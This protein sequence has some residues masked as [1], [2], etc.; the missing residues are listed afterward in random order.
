M[1]WGNSLLQSACCPDFAQIGA[2]PCY[3]QSLKGATAVPSSQHAL[4]CFEEQPTAKVPTSTSPFSHPGWQAPEFLCPLQ[5]HLG[6]SKS[7]GQQN[8][9]C[10]PE[11]PRPG[12]I[13]HPILCVIRRFVPS[14]GTLLKPLGQSSAQ[15]DHLQSLTTLRPITRSRAGCTPRSTTAHPSE[16][17][18][19]DSDPQQAAPRRKRKLSELTASSPGQRLWRQRDGRGSQGGYKHTTALCTQKCL[20]GLQRGDTLDA[21]CSNVEEHRSTDGGDKYPID[22]ARLAGLIKQQL[23]ED[24]DRDCTPFGTSGSYGAPFRIT[25]RQYSYTV[26]GKGT[27]RLRWG[28]VRREAE[29]YRV[30]QEV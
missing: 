27:T 1:K 26:L 15:F 20:L 2:E 30:L 14:R 5:R 11:L 24:L 25:C 13:S 4:W 19:S 22:A 23:D 16:L 3:L 12:Y 17:T 8:V 21:G 28:E 10:P 7:P 29:V 9:D 6:I 18:D